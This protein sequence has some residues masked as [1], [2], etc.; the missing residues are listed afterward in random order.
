MTYLQL[1]NHFY[2]PILEHYI[3]LTHTYTS[4]KQNLSYQGLDIL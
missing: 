1:G 2:S 4:K 3:T